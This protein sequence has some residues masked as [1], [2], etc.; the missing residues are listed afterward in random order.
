MN[1]KLEILAPAG[2][3]DILKA[4]IEAGADAVY[5]GG[6]AF[7]ARAYAN[8]FTQEELLYALD[9]AHARGRQIYMT[10]NTL[11]KNQEIKDVVSYLQPYYLGGLDAV[12]VQDFGVM[13][14]IHEAFPD[15]PIH[16]ST[17]MTVT[18][19]D[20]V[21]LLQKYGV[22]RVVMAREVSL[23]EMKK[24]HDETGMEIEAFVH[25]ALC[26]S[27]S[28]QCLFSSL[29]GGR[30]GNRG[31]CAQP[32]RLPYQVVDG[33]G[34]EI[35]KE[36]YILSLKDMC[37]L[38]D[39]RAL[40][41]NGVFS[42]K[43]EGRMKSAEYAAGVVSLYRKYAD[44]IEAG[45][46]NTKVSNK[47]QQRILDLGNRCGFT[48]Q[49]YYRQNGED[50]VT[51]VKPNFQTKATA[52]DEEVR[53]RYIDHQEKLTVS[54]YASFAE[55]QE[56]W[57]CLTMG[58][59]S[60]TAMGPVP[61][62]ALKKPL[63][64][65]DVKNRLAKLGDSPFVMSEMQ[66]D[67]NGN[68]FLPNGAINA[69]RRD[70]V[71]LLEDEVFSQYHRVLPE[72]EELDIHWENVSYQTETNHTGKALLYSASCLTWD[73]Y[74]AAMETE[75]I[76]RIYME[77]SSY[78]IDHDFSRVSV[79]AAS[80]H[81]VKK[82]F[83]LA[84]PVIFR[85]RTSRVFKDCKEAFAEVDGFLVRNLEELYWVSETWPNKDIITDHNL[86]QYN[87]MATAAFRSE[88]VSAST[89]PLELN[90]SEIL[91]RD[92][93]TTEM[94]VYGRYPLMT[95]AGCVHRNTTGCDRK[96][97]ILYLKDRYKVAFPVHNNCGEC[98]NIIYNSLPTC[99]FKQ[100]AELE[101]LEDHH[102]VR[103]FRLSFTTE[104]YEKTRKVLSVFS[105]HVSGRALPQDYDA[106]GQTTGGHYKRG[107]E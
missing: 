8:N 49:Y 80:A 85:D 57:L 22:K 47:D 53:R 81:A 27:Y 99:L 45:R 66:V 48:N 88:G 77:S 92:N 50:M 29:L 105:R 79:D 65:E 90:R 6:P 31:R 43:I 93:R 5:L 55:G 51:Y 102:K 23:A 107:V 21:R 89:M 86:Y 56:S 70:A 91:H 101:G 59:I 9:Y 44:A 40:Y 18:G 12:L 16:T 10:V 73:Q 33:K 35:S 67:M 100:M 68:V 32:C 38:S 11:L 60:V 46:L 84:L 82:E 30:S 62:E 54:G 4:V 98:M 17:Q 34:K 58:D 26:Y 87:D 83:F 24:I 76:S 3:L 61:L 13:K 63:D 1:K 25:G 20:G 41:E 69:L 2:S 36:T 64:P 78:G 75:E 97:Q 74:R 28:G 96:P 72:T 103:A 39:L 14:A 71:K 19:S 95:T 7:G 94:V 15:L 106:L 104:D 37:G 42:L 52:Y